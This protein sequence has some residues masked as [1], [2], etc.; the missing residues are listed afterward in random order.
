MTLRRMAIS[1]GVGLL[2]LTFLFLASGLSH[3]H[4]LAPGEGTSPQA[5]SSLPSA[6]PLSETAPSTTGSRCFLCVLQRMSEAGWALGGDGESADVPLSTL[7]EV[8]AL[9]PPR[10]LA[11]ILAARGPPVA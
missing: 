2:V 6:G 7:P 5:L 1:R 8:A 10:L 11:R 3:H 9:L 4:L